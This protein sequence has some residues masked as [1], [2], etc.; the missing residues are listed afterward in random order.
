MGRA[1]KSIDEAL[2]RYEEKAAEPEE[3]ET[4]E[5]PDV[6]NA[7]DWHRSLA[8]NWPRDDDQ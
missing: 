7:E 3:P 5:E 2:T 4:D 1:N 8:H 6:G